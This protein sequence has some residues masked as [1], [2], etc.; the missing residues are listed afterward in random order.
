MTPPDAAD[1]VAALIPW[2]RRHRRDLPWRREVDPYRVLLSELMLQQ[3]RVDTVVPYFER[4]VARWPDLASLAAADEEEVLREWSGLGYYSRARNLLRCARLVA[5]GG[6]PSTVS[7]LRALPGIGPYTAG[8]VA[9]IAYGVSAPLVDGNVERVLCRLDARSED[10]RGAGRAPLWARATE[11]HRAAGDEIHPG[12]LNQALMEL[13]ATV[14]TP[15]APSCVRCPVAAGCRAH[16]QGDPLAYPRRAPRRRPTP[17]RGVAGLLWIDGGIVLGRRPAGLLGGLWEPVGA[18]H[19]GG[20]EPEAALVAAFATQ[21]GVEIE[22]VSRLG[23]VVHTFTHRRLTTIV[24]E[25]RG[26]G[27]PTP[28]ARYTEVR[29]VSDPESVPLSTLARRILAVGPQLGLPLAAE[30]S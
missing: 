8:A 27:A 28:K 18:E 23:V 14:C 25:V 2:Y 5:E 30:G 11:L 13:G 19:P 3:T 15:R 6:L 7:E 4:F 21:V 1:L 20:V 9:S 24:Y 17:V 12:D 22:I 10:P 26:S 29:I 16:G